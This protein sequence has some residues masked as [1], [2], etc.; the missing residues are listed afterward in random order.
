MAATNSVKARQF[1]DLCKTLKYIILQRLS[2]GLL[3]HLADSSVIDLSA[4]K[5]YAYLL[6]APHFYKIALEMI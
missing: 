2:R 1:R 3:G 4:A 6:F 5:G